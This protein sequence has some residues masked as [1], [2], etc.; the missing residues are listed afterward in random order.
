MGMMPESS[1]M[2]ATGLRLLLGIVLDTLFK[3]TNVV[4]PGG[5]Y[6]LLSRGA[7]IVVLLV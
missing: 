3:S 6:S 7:I 1:V 5:K 2:R 4:F